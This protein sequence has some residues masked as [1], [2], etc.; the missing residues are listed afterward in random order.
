M[1]S[2]AITPSFTGLKPIYILPKAKGNV[3]RPYL[4]NEVLDMSR[5]LKVPATFH[6][7]KIILPEPTQAVITKLNE[8]GISYKNVK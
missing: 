8:L 1:S 2:L 6:N 7:E 3:N 5:K 4:Y